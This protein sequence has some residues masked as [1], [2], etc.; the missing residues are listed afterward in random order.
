MLDE[1]VISTKLCVEEILL[2]KRRE[3]TTKLC[4]NMDNYTEVDNIN[5]TKLLCR[6]ISNVHSRS[7]NNQLFSK[8]REPSGDRNFHE[9]RNIK[10]GDP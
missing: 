7:V 4:R 2:A 10:G 5:Q 9:D 6:C 3:E 8:H 1:I